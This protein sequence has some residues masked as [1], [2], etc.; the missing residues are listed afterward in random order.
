MVRRSGQAMLATALLGWSAP[1]LATPAGCAGRLLPPQAVGAHSEL[2]AR[3]LIELR[4]FG[5]PTVG[6]GGASPFSLSPD[7]RLAALILRRA[8]VDSDDYCHGV[9]I[10]SLHGDAPPRL[11]DVGGEYIPLT[12]DLRGSADFTNG[13]PAMVTPLWSPDGRRLAYLRRE[14]GIN[15]LW[16]APL[17]GGAAK[18]VSHFASDVAAFRWSGNDR[19]IAST[20]VALADARAAITSEGRR[21]F[22]FDR[23]FFP[24]ID[25]RPHA[26]STIPFDEIV[27]RL[28]SRESAPADMT[29]PTVGPD[30]PR[31]ALLY[32]RSPDGAEAWTAR[33]DPA[34]P[35][36]DIALHVVREGHHLAC[37]AAICAAHIAGLWWLGPDDLLFVRAGSGDNGGRDAI[38]RWRLDRERSPS[39]V[40]STT[41]ALIGCQLSGQQLY[42]AHEGALSPRS[43]IVIDLRRGTSRTVFQP[44]PDFPAG[45][46][47]SVRRLVWTDAKGVITYGDLVLPPDHRAGQRHPMVVTQYES[48]GFLRGGTGDEV[49]IQLL[50]SRGFAVL[51]TQRPGLLPIAQTAHDFATMQHA[52]IAGFA[53]RLQLASAVQAGVDAAIA[54]G[55]VDERHLGLT[56]MSDGAVTAQFILSRPNRFQAAALSSC[57][58]DPGAA[59]FAAG[60]GYR[61]DI[62]ASGYPSPVAPDPAFWHGYSLAATLN[63]PPTPFLLQVADD[64][65]RL[66]LE[67]FGTLQLRHVPVDMF[68]YPDEHHWKWHPAHR[69]AAYRR[70]IAWFDFWLRGIKSS[71]PA[72]AED[73]RR[74]TAMRSSPAGS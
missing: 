42:C 37:P 31:G 70:N 38:Y 50:A 51:S 18:E 15:Q 13:S 44:N 10:V 5:A 19:I 56:G 49:P 11:V 64:E 62:I 66:A 74:W 69:F 46:L 48:R 3:S 55:T 2:T 58:D 40:R 14:L 28:G 23:R 36:A 4:D 67:T 8:N 65:Y 32:A 30:Q 39:L 35:F 63:A 43:L 47:G 21:G 57:C 59:M 71:D 29:A 72:E 9:V 17:D 6:I 1:A 22:H 45:G 16:I 52:N 41:D 34:A 53:D 26:A 20:R 27:I 60:L 33:A 24:L 7:G 54:T 25:I 73:I 61:D 68:V 12:H